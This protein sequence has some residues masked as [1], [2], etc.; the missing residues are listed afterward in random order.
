[1]GAESKKPPGTW[2]SALSVASEVLAKWGLVKESYVY[3]N[4]SGL[5]NANRFSSHQLVT[6][7][8]AVY[9][10]S[11]IRPEFLSQ[12][13]IGGVDGTIKSN[14]REKAAFRRVRAKTGT[15]DDVSALS[16]YVFDEQG[17][18]PI[19]FSIMVNDASGYVSASRT[20]QERI[21]TEIAKFL[22]P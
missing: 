4:G 2:Q 12:L 6:V 5:F 1:M 15:L 17:R 9:L 7:L 21:V 14:F 22:N 11:S 18:R 16:G 10:D 20:Y 3:R 13:A 8:R 19:A